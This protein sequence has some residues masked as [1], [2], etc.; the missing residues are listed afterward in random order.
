MGTVNKYAFMISE[1]LKEVLGR[2]EQKDAEDFAGAIVRAEKVFLI[3]VGRVFLALKCFG[4]RLV[5]LQVD[6]HV[7]G[8]VTE[9]PISARDLLVVASGSGESKIPLAIAQIAKSKGAKIVLITSAS[10]S[11]LKKLSDI[12]VTIPCPTKTETSRGI[13]SG[14]PMSTLFDQAVHLFGDAIALRIMELKNMKPDDLWRFHAN[15]E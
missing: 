12:T 8:S 3:A 14:Q 4:K 11:A 6:T 13:S 5:H 9:K 7:V 1:E 15:L 10:S 2:V